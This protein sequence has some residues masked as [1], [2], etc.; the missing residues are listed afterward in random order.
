MEL[1]DGDYFIL[2]DN[3]VIS[4]DSREIGAVREEDIVGVVIYN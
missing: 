3:R 2:G 4:K 1:G